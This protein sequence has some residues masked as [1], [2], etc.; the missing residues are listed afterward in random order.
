MRSPR[1]YWISA[2]TSTELAHNEVDDRST[3][4][5]KSSLPQAIQFVSGALPP[6]NGVVMGIFQDL[7][8]LRRGLRQ[9]HHQRHLAVGGEAIGL[10]GAYLDGRFDHPLARHDA[11]Q[12]RSD[13][14]AS[15]YCVRGGNG[16][17]E[18]D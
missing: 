10:E 1:T 6:D 4:S 15:P 8:N 7:G 16:H 18:H 9:H 2:I 3:T 12:R 5:Q 17:C 14:R 13:L 11:A